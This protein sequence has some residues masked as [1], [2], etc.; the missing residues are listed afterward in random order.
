MD[1]TRGLMIREARAEDGAAAQAVTLAAYQQYAAIMPPWAWER[2]KED[3]AETVCAPAPAEHMVAELEGALV[4]SVLL[5][6][7]TREAPGPA[8]VTFHRDAPE[9][10]I[11]AVAPEARG[12]G[13][14]R[15]LMDECIRRARAAGY[16]S[17][18]LHTN[19][20]MAAAVHLY[21]STGWVRAPELDFHPAEN[22]VIKGYR[23]DL[24]VPGEGH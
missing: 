4:G 9:V 24:G 6:P 16:P 8:G 23:L 20:M 17:I 22:I 14:G 12:H 13:V 5:F 7:P 11:L 19:D 21:E 1:N 2:Y 3:L 10:R 15:A 18:T